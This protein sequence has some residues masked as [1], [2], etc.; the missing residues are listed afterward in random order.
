MVITSTWTVNL[1]T[2]Y[3]DSLCSHA[4]NHLMSQGC[5]ASVT[6]RQ[7]NMLV[8]HEFLRAHTCS[9]GHGN[10][11]RRFRIMWHVSITTR[12]LHV[13]TQHIIPHKVCALHHCIHRNLWLA[14]PEPP[15]SPQD[16]NH[17]DQS[18]KCT[19]ESCLA[20]NRIMNLSVSHASK[21][22]HCQHSLLTRRSC[23]VNKAVTGHPHDTSGIND[24]SSRSY[25]RTSPTHC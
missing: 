6:L 2:L 14:K 17:T 18:F 25:G 8:R 24:T 5:R 12:R 7:L 9:Q 1:W 21:Q 11:D 4:D 20:H 13:A 16:V 22:S 10:V 23:L 3:K 19:Y 15:V